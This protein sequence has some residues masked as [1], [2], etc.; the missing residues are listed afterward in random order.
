MKCQT[1]M[2]SFRNIFLFNR[3]VFSNIKHR[4]VSIEAV[5]VLKCADVLMAIPVE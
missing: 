5:P 2:P 4:D 3:F 1:V